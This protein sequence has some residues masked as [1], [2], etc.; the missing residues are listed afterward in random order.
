M[1]FKLIGK[2]DITFKNKIQSIIPK[3]QPLFCSVWIYLGFSK[4]IQASALLVRICCVMIYLGFS[5]D[6]QARLY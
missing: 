6:I 3:L 5:K 4:D 2:G 1:I